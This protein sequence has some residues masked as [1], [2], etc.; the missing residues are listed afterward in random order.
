MINYRKDSWDSIII[1]ITDGPFIYTP[2][3]FPWTKQR[4]IETDKSR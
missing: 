2:A 3:E 4:H 1:I